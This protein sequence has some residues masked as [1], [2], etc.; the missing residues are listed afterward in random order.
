MTESAVSTLAAVIAVSIM[1]ALQEVETRQTD[2]M[3]AW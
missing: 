1:D 2:M 3:T